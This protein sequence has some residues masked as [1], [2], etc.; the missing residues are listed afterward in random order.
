MWPLTLT[1]QHPS[2]CYC[3]LTVEYTRYIDWDPDVA[4]SPTSCPYCTSVSDSWRMWDVL[5]AAETGS[6]RNSH[7]AVLAG[8]RDFSTI[9]VKWM[10][11]P[12]CVCVRLTIPPC[13][14]I[15]VFLMVCLF[16]NL[17]VG[18]SFKLFPS[19]P[20]CSHNHTFVHLF[21]R[22]WKTHWAHDHQ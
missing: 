5:T 2:S 10:F 13:V 18:E 9:A 14:W 21:K 22:A 19:T 16:L 15:L 11:V 12:K 1:P 8:R 4:L 3:T 17:C 6:G 20:Q 7:V